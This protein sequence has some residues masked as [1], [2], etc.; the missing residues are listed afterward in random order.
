MLLGDTTGWCCYTKHFWFFNKTLILYKLHKEH[1]CVWTE[2]SIWRPN[3]DAVRKLEIRTWNCSRIESS[4][5]LFCIRWKVSLAEVLC[6][7]LFGSPVGARYNFSMRLDEAS[8]FLIVSHCKLSKFPRKAKFA[9][10]T[11]KGGHSSRSNQGFYKKEFPRKS[12][13]GKEFRA[14]AERQQQFVMC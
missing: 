8:Q 12:K 1:F 6:T 5:L 3:L 9:W 11:F 14:A 4:V 7:G 10:Q 13:K 2:A